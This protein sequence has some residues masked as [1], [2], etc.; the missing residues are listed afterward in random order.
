VGINVIVKNIK[1]VEMRLKSVDSGMD[2]SEAKNSESGPR[3]VGVRAVGGGGEWG[4][5]REKAKEFFITA[6]NNYSAL[7]AT[8][9]GFSHSLTSYLAV[10]DQPGVST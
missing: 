6:V 8:L 3:G 5:D 7:P 10:D 1:I 9:N 2:G 4:G